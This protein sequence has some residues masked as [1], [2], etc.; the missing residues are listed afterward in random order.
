MPA[1]T[2]SPSPPP[3]VDPRARISERIW[4]SEN[5][6]RAFDASFIYRLL[7]QRDAD[8]LAWV[9]NAVYDSEMRY[10]GRRML[11]DEISATVVYTYT[12]T[13]GTLYI[14]VLGRL[15]GSDPSNPEYN[16][17]ADLKN[18][19]PSRVLPPAAVT[20]I[21]NEM[22]RNMD[23]RHI[24]VVSLADRL[25][26]RGGGFVNGAYAGGSVT[27]DY[28][29]NGDTARLV[30]MYERGLSGGGVPEESLLARYITP[31]PG[32]PPGFLPGYVK[33]SSWPGYL[34]TGID[35]MEAVMQHAD[36]V[37]PAP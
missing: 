29:V 8:D 31:A 23:R 18:L 12:R 21:Q 34:V 33:I 4:E 22:Q 14:L 19:D 13:G 9:T 27:E 10:E 25:V 5:P 28:W 36:P 32:D 3:V 7:R 2:S 30:E 1:P 24:P 26:Y 15:A 16:V 35:T 6:A 20:L 37:L 17:Y 11:F